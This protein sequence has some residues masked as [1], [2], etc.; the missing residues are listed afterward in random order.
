MKYI[1]IL[2]LSLFVFPFGAFAVPQNNE[3]M[4]AAQ[5]LAAARNADIQQVQ[6]LVNS[7]ANINYV[8]ATGLSVVC[9]ALM[10]NDTRAAQILQMYGAD[11]SQCDRQIKNYNNRTKPKPSGGLFGGLSS[12]QN[13]TL[14]AA[15]AAV[16]VGGL[17]LLTDVF[18]P[19]N[20]NENGNLSGG[21]RP[22]TGGNTGGNDNATSTITVPYGPA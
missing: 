2:F 20:N 13:M 3:F 17:L 15:G 6:M 7:G 12:V 14:A 4:A 19:G 1:R 11:A 8:D 18:D 16:V 9:T 10:N 22:G 21:T 5:L